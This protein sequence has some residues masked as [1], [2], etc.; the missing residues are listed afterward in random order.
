MIGA[1]VRRT[2]L[3]MTWRGLPGVGM[4]GRG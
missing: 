4:R 1:A 3:I 2:G